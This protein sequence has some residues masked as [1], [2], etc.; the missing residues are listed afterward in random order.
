[1]ASEYYIA[2]S[3]GSVAVQSSVEQ[4]DEVVSDPV[5]AM[6]SVTATACVY[7]LSLGRG[8]TYGFMEADR[9]S[10]LFNRR[11]MQMHSYA[12]CGRLSARAVKF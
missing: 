11:T 5:W 6:G 2:R 4:A 8:N 3:V 1:M 9:E 10:T 7:K 12:I